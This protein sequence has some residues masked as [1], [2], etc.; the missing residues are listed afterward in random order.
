MTKITPT[1]PIDDNTN[2]WASISWANDYVQDILIDYASPNFKVIEVDENYPLEY[3]SVVLYKTSNKKLEFGVVTNKKGQFTIDNVKPGTYYLEASFIGYQ[4]K[5]L[6]S[7]VITKKGEKKDVGTI[8]LILGSGNQLNEVVIKSEKNT[9]LHKIDRQVFDSK[10]YLLPY[11]F[12]AD[13]SWYS[14]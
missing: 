13:Y 8:K 2:Q 7:I 3:A 12:Y 5:T 1:V 4:V 10:K 14:F 11:M 6:S 9:V